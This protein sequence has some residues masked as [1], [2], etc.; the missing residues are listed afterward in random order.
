MK[1]FFFFFLSLSYISCLFQVV[2]FT[3]MHKIFS[4]LT[5]QIDQGGLTDQER[6]QQNEAKLND[7]RALSIVADDWRKS[8]SLFARFY[9]LFVPS[10]CFSTV[11]R[12][13]YGITAV[14]DVV[15]MYRECNSTSIQKLE[16]VSS[17]SLCDLGYGS[18]SSL[19]HAKTRGRLPQADTLHYRAKRL[20][21]EGS[22]WWV[23]HHLFFVCKRYLM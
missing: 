4:D 19:F 17:V 16:S 20:K 14:N 23:E 12:L 13:R 2:Y 11:R 10:D 18:I 5:D 1:A 3:E 9:S 8:R 22:R 7:L 15:K 21:S 6:E